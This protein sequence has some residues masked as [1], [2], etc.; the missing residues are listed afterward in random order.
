MNDVNLKGLM[1]FARVVEHGGF[2]PAGRTLGVA[3]STLSKQVAELERALGARLIQRNSRRF[4]VTELGREV[5][6][7]AAAMVGEAEA[8]EDVVQGRL[9]EP[10]GIVRITASI[11]TTRLSLAPIIPE[12]VRT[13]PK[14]RVALQATDRFVD[15]VQE[16]FDIGLRS[17]FGPLPDSGLVQRRLRFDPNILVVSPAY[18]DARGVSL[19]VAAIDDC[20][21][22][23]VSPGQTRWLA[24]AASG[25]TAE[26]SPKPRLFA[27][28]AAVLLAAAKAGIGIACLPHRLCE[29]DL[30]TGAI[31]RVLPDWTVGGVTT[32]LL[33]PARRGLLP[34]VRAAADFL[35]AHLS[36]EDDIA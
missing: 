36:G 32:T 4:T 26:I 8:A 34:S 7:H 16:G 14:I 35:V 6:R 27:D 9:A 3:K 22:V 12:L 19:S 29:T 1:A 21:G 25:E 24:R 2:S 15:L 23:F 30:E 31:V 10:S 13:Y 33:M 11:P 20:D 17:H 18:L 5:Y 28:D